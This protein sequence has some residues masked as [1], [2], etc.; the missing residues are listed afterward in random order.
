MLTQICRVLLE[1]VMPDDVALLTITQAAKVLQVSRLTLRGW[2]DEGRIPW[3]DVGS[4]RRIPYWSLRDWQ[5]RL[6]IAANALKRT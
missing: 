2:L 5:S 3:I 4:Q 6:I 1:I